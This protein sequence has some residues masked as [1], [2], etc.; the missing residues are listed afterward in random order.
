M[1]IARVDRPAW[2]HRVIIGLLIATII[3]GTGLILLIQSGATNPKPVGELA[4]VIEPDTLISLNEAQTLHNIQT[5]IAFSSPGT[6]D[7][8]MRQISGPTET[9]YGIRAIRGGDEFAAVGVS[10]NGF[11]GVFTHDDVIME[12]QPWPHIRQAGDVNQLRLNLFPG[13]QVEVWVNSE[14]AVS[15]EWPIVGDLQLD[16]FIETLGRGGAEIRVEQIQLWEDK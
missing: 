4:E 12:W 13:G 14:F 10:S 2:V 16:Y 1:S 3:T 6:V 15:F 7:V 5:A 8:N 9:R 11:I